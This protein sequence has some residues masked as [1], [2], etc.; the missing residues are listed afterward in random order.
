MTQARRVILLV[1]AAIGWGSAATASK[2]ALRGLR[3]GWAHAGPRRIYALLG[4]F[5]PGLAYAG[6]N[7][8][9]AYTSAVN[10]ALLDG[11]ESCFVVLLAVLV[12][13]ERLSRRAAI[14]ALSSA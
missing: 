7:F 8:G 6:L 14:A 1:L 3:G 12:L 9:L 13:R 11:L 10:G 4:F 5:E 2:Y